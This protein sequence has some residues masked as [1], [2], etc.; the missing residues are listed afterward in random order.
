MSWT[1][2]CPKCD[3]VL[4]PDDSVMLIVSTAGTQVLV[5]FHPQP[6]NYTVYTPPG[7]EFERGKRY[8]YYCPLCRQNL[9]VQQKEAVSALHLKQ[10][11][12][13]RTVLFSNISGKCDT[14]VIDEPQR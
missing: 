13:V 6:G 9:I 2:S 5:G 10:G 11:D 4:N 7:F 3:S 12:A 8:E 1:Y 14:R